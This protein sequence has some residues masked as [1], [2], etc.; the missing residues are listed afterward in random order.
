MR[1]SLFQQYVDQASVG[2]A[3][4]ANQVCYGHLVQETVDGRVFVDRQQTE[5]TSLEEATT[6]IRHQKLTED[7]EQEIQQEQYSQISNN[8]IVDIIKQYHKDVRVTDTLIESYVELASSKIFTT[9][10]VAT[11]IRNLN[12]LD[13]LL[14]THVDFVLDDG[15]VIVISEQAHQVINNVFGHHL[16]VVEYMRSSKENF[17][18]VLNQLED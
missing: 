2:S 1:Y 10:P 11:E 14:E 6:H 17:L 3:V 16:D 18:A 9:D 7:L 4:A 8:K 5:F 15:S 12:K 13:R